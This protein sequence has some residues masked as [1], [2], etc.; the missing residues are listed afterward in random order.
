M[1][2]L[3]LI[4]YDLVGPGKDYESMHRVIDKAGGVRVLLSQWLLPSNQNATDVW[5]A[6]RPI[7]DFNDR[8]LVTEITANTQ[9]TAERLLISDAKMQQLIREYARPERAYSRF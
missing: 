9:W 3:Y 8:L 7:T 5:K 6:L 4:N 2:V 1:A